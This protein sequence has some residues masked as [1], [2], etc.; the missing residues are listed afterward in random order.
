VV[1]LLKV[2]TLGIGFA[3]K[4]VVGVC[5]LQMILVWILYFPLALLWSQRVVRGAV[6]L[7]VTVWAFDSFLELFQ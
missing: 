3:Q 7:L 5:L 4:Y 1:L 6:S 2:L